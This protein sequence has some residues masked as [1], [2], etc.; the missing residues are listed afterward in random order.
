MGPSTPCP[1]ADHVD[2]LVK[3]SILIVDDEKSIRLTVSMSLEPLGIPI[4]AAV[5]GEEALE[6]LAKEGARLILP[7][8][9]V[10]GMDGIEVLQQ[11]AGE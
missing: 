1:T 10:P 11:I 7:D 2:G 4:E 8:L 3:E 6:K 9:K 5:H